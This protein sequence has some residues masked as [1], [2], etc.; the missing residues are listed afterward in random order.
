M[1]QNGKKVRV[2]WQRQ[3]S[4]SLL[5]KSL[6][7]TP[8]LHSSIH[9]PDY[10]LILRKWV[11]QLL[12]FQPGKVFFFFR[13]II[14]FYIY[15]PVK[16]GGIWQF[17]HMEGPKLQQKNANF[18]TIRKFFSGEFRH[19]ASN[20]LIKPTIWWYKTWQE[21]GQHFDMRVKACLN[22]NVRPIA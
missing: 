20:N 18:D 21:V 9:L 10:Q 4:L 2:F 1:G 14:V 7:T 8:L 11:P 6:H 16:F 13:R 3:V 19:E 15:L 12:I 5:N 17:L 22:S